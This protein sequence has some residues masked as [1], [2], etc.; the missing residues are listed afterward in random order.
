MAGLAEVL[1]AVA[2]V[3]LACVRDVDGLFGCF[4]LALR[5]FLSPCLCLDLSACGCLC[6]RLGLRLSLCAR[7]L[8]LRALL[9]EGS[10]R[11]LVDGYIYRHDY[12]LT[13]G[14][15]PGLVA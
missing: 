11:L 15:R 12:V 2:V 13:F 14:E 8:L 3:L 6:F 5:L 9:C 4:L 10:R 7:P 1:T